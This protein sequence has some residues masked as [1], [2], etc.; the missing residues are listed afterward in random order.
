MHICT[1][2]CVHTHTHTH[3]ELIGEFESFASQDLDAEDEREGSM[4]KQTT[5]VLVPVF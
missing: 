1:C 3:T 5:L 4:V 2:T